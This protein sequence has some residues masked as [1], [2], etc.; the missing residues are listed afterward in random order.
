[1]TIFLTCIGNGGAIHQS[2]AEL[3][4]K[5]RDCVSVRKRTASYAMRHCLLM[6]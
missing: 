4:K 6:K 2:R 1:M 5:C 3:I